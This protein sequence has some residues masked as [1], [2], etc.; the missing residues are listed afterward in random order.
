M[1]DRTRSEDTVAHAP[2][3]TSVH[4]VSHSRVGSIPATDIDAAGSQSG[5]DGDRVATRSTTAVIVST[6]LRAE[7]RDILERTLPEP[8]FPS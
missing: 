8:L 7:L 1:T 6:C 4:T 2:A 3:A 5:T